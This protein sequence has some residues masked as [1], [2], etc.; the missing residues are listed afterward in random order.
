MRVNNTKENELVK[1]ILA[2]GCKDVIN[3]PNVSKCFSRLKNYNKELHRHSVNVAI[4]SVIIAIYTNKSH[5]D[6]TDLFISGL[7]HDYGKLYVPE[8]IIN[9]SGILTVLE[10]KE[11]EKH[12]LLGYKYLKKEMYFSN[13]ILLGVL[14]H[15]ERVDGKGYTEAKSENNISE[16]AKIIMVADVYD[17]MISDRVYRSRLER[18]IVYEYLFSNAGKY[19]SRPLVKGF[20]NNTFTMDLN[21]VIKESE[22]Q[23]MGYADL[24]VARVSYR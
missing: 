2:T 17:A 3:N 4:L 12:V 23:I 16:F 9:K 14:E 24:E 11:I 13:N 7:L 8:K 22:R 10:R 15:H 21:Y 19:F 5:S 6:M 18:G 20:I 1:E